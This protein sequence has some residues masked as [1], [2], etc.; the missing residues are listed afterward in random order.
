MRFG[1]SMSVFNAIFTVEDNK[2]AEA[3][4]RDV[5]NWKKKFVEAE[6]FLDRT[7]SEL[8]Q[9][10][11][12]FEKKEVKYKEKEDALFYKDNKKETD[13]TYQEYCRANFAFAKILEDRRNNRSN[14][15]YAIKEFK[16]WGIVAATDVDLDKD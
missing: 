11:K 4:K 10:K 14:I 8:E 15:R 1:S 2:K 5:E 6:K 12:D 9:K 16:K 13:K 3:N 7:K